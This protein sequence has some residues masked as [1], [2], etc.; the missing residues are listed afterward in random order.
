MD[1]QEGPFQECGFFPAVPNRIP[2]QDG[3]ELTK[4]IP[5]AFLSRLIPPEFR[6]AEL[7]GLGTNQVRGEASYI[8]PKLTSTHGFTPGYAIESRIRYEFVGFLQCDKFET[9]VETFRRSIE[10]RS[11]APSS[12]LNFN[13]E[14]LK[15]YAARDI[16]F[17]D[18]TGAA[19]LCRIWELEKLGEKF[20]EQSRT[21]GRTASQEARE[22][23]PREILLRAIQERL[24]TWRKEMVAAQL[25]AVTHSP[26]GARLD[27]AA[28]ELREREAGFH[29]RH[30]DCLAEVVSA[31]LPDLAELHA[32]IQRRDCVL[33]EDWVSAYLK[34]VEGWLGL[35]ELHLL[36]H[37]AP[38]ESREKAMSIY[39]AV[40][41]VVSL[42]GDK[43]TV[44]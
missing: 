41:R 38:E 16:P 42:D 15:H 6:L 19:F 27:A 28:R 29:Q 26:H 20:A 32:V 44:D 9:K 18:Y 5:S 7:L 14:K 17:Q 34:R 11:R 1:P 25:L 3:A 33:M 43:V 12:T 37:E 30:D 39:L 4:D 10:S 31:R 13:P 23:G 22:V 2:F 21:V 24:D 40:A 8:D 35:R 36:V